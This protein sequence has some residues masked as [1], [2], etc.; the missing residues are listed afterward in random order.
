MTS[1]PLH[2]ED[3]D[4]DHVVVHQYIRLFGRRPSALELAQFRQARSRSRYRAGSALSRR[5]VATLI[6]R[7]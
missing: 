4:D 3:T 5:V 7:L 2:L 1:S 6:S